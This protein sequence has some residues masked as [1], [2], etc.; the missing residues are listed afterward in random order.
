[1]CVSLSIGLTSVIMHQHTVVHQPHSVFAVTKASACSS[2]TIAAL[3]P[4]IVLFAGLDA[5]AQ[6]GFEGTR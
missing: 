1:M 3:S 4:S 5:L 6:S 2:A